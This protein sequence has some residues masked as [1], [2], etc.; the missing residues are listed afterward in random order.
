M[1]KFGTSLNIEVL[2]HS[3]PFDDLLHLLKIDAAETF[4]LENG[5]FFFVLF[6]LLFLFL[7]VFD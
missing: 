4:F 7:I 1:A 2:F 3:S 6:Y 5:F